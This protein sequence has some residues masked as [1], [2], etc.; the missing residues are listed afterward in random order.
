MKNKV[1][2]YFLITKEILE[3]EPVSNKQDSD[4]DKDIF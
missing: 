1:I 2:I 4:E 3:N